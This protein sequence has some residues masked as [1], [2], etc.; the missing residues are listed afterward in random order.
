M[1]DQPRCA[2]T[3]GYTLLE[4]LA[5]ASI[6]MLIM[7]LSASV[8]IGTKRLHTLGTLAMDR[9]EA[10]EDVARDFREAVRESAA[11][12]DFAA[13]LPLAPGTVAL[14][15]KAADGATRYRLWRRDDAGRFYF[16]IYDVRP[17]RRLTLASRTVYSP[18]VNVTEFSLTRDPQT[19]LVSLDLVVDNEGTPRSV[20]RT[21][22]FVAAL[23]AP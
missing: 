11:T 9:N 4:V 16:E 14:T 6:L 17:D 1:N 7:N 2:G 19:A 12:V 13:G 18:S 23:G 8:L 3:G 5:Y 22:H 21:N 20:S 10:I 15:S